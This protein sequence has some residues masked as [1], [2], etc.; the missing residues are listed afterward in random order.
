MES[1][2]TATEGPI[3]QKLVNIAQNSIAQSEVV[4]PPLDEA[5]KLLQAQVETP[6]PQWLGTSHQI[7]L[8]DCW[9]KVSYKAANL[10]HFVYFLLYLV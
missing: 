5:I 10:V 6:P 9:N 1:V 2:T 7:V 3:S 4:L 8:G